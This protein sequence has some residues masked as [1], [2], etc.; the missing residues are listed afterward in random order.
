MNGKGLTQIYRKLLSHFGPQGWWPAETAFEVVLGAILT[1][2][3]SWSNVEK[4]VENLNA[5]NLLEPLRLA[6][7]TRERIEKAVYPAGFYRQKAERLLR[8]AHYLKKHYQGNLS[9]FFDQPLEKLRSEL[10]NINGIG[11]ETCDSILLYA[12]NKLIFP[13]DAYTVRMCRRLGL[14]NLEGHEEL[15]VFFEQRLPPELDIYNE[16]HALIVRWAKSYCR[17]KKPLC[18]N[19]PLAGECKM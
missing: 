5:Q 3:T 19:C 14:T 12:A 10:L 4:A 13:I 8:F 6:R 7:A 16:F 11:P 2:N 1:Q 18:D 17:S 9:L 15:R